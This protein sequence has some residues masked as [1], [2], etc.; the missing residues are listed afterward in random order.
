M[1]AGL[2]TRRYPAGLEPVGPQVEQAASGTSKS[3]IS[4]RF[5]AATAE[6]LAELLARRLEDRRWLGAQRRS[7][8]RTLR[9]MCGADGS[10]GKDAPF[11]P[12][13]ARPCLL[14]DQCRRGWC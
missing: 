4:R 1:L 6:R 3:A 11:P 13:P 10:G 9:G 7:A 14:G 2:S 5:V 8:N 12:C